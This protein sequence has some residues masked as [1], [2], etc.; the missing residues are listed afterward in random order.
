MC[1]ENSQE[2][3]EEGIELLLRAL[4]LAI[5]HDQHKR[6]R[7]QRAQCPLRNVQR[8]LPPRRFAYHTR[9]LADAV[10]AARV[11]NRVQHTLCGR[12]QRLRHHRV[13]L[14][15]VRAVVL[16]F[17]DV[18]A[19]EVVSQEATIIAVRNETATEIIKNNYDFAK[20][21]IQS[22]TAQ[23]DKFQQLWVD[24]KN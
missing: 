15:A 10:H 7:R 5:Q 13:R 3:P 12:A 9:V 20:A 11:H 23:V 8:Q 22:I 1:P 4:L 18:F 24:N 17:A 14:R 19:H 21:V 16:Q 2:I 6:H